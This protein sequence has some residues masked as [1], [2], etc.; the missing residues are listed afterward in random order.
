[1]H[2]LRKLSTNIHNFKWERQSKQPTYASHLFWKPDATTAFILNLYSVTPS[3]LSAE[4][5]RN[6]DCT[7]YH[8]S[9]GTGKTGGEIHGLDG[10]HP[11]AFICRASQAQRTACQTKQTGSGH[12]H[13]FHLWCLLFSSLLMTTWIIV[14]ILSPEYISYLFT[15]TYILTT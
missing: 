3:E 5:M 2:L 9:T 11:G 10:E 6:E 14:I 8:R 1:M 13:L 4:Y 12:S 7:H 15:F